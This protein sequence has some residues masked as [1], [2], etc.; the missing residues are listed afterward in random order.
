MGNGE[1][2]LVV[3]DESAIRE[4]GKEAL[5]TFGYRVLT[6]NDGTEALALFAQHRNEVHCVITD[7]MMPFMDGPATIRALRKLAPDL[8]II[9]TSGLKADGKAAEAAQLGVATFLQNT[10]EALLK[11]LAAEL[12]KA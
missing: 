3:D 9:A 5:R 7:M 10:A 1:L 4:I 6:A 8:K 12:R 11:T 2:I